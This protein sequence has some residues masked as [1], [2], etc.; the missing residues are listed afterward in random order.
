V[1]PHCDEMSTGHWSERLKKKSED[2]PQMREESKARGRL[3]LTLKSSWHGR[4]GREKSKE[5]M[6]IRK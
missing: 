6:I 2:H 5:F 4:G 1:K 3:A